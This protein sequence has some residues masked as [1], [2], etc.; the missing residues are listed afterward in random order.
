MMDKGKRL[1]DERMGAA[2]LGSCEVEMQSNIRS[3]S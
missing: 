2:K 3:L 1:K